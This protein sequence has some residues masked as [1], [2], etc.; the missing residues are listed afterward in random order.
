ML[1][2]YFA[3]KHNKL[4]FGDNRLVGVGKMHTVTC[5]PVLCESGLHG[6]VRVMDALDY[7]RSAML[8]RVDITRNVRIGADKICGQH[9]KYL[10]GFDATDVLREFG[11]KQAL[12]NVSKVKPHCTASEYDEI[13]NWLDTGNPKIR[14]SAF[15]AAERVRNKLANSR[16]GGVSLNVQAAADSVS[17]SA[18]SPGDRDAWQVAR[19]SFRFA[20]DS[21]TV[22]LS[23]TASNI[24]LPGIRTTANEMLTE[25]VEAAYGKSS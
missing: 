20:V 4:G 7:A 8:Y 15:N 18:R 5:V 23:Q 2:W 24:I 6:S 10:S 17:E 12:I 25:M 14:A 13:I 3:G 1:A 21:V 9:R 19:C 22:R 16:G 11:R